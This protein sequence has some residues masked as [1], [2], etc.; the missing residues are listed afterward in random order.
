MTQ[1]LQNTGVIRL[2]SVQSVN[3]EI[4]GD[5]R[6]LIGQVVRLRLS[7]DQDEPG[8][9]ASVLAKFS[10]PDP[11]FRLG[12]AQMYRR[13]I[14]FYDTVASQLESSVPRCYFGAMDES[15]G[16]S[17][18][19]IEDVVHA[20]TGDLVEGCTIPEAELA[21]KQLAHIHAA[22]WG[23]PKLIDWHWMPNF[24]EAGRAD[25]DGLP[26]SEKYALFRERMAEIFPEW[27]LPAIFHAT[28][29]ALGEHIVLA[30]QRLSELPVTLL[31]NDP[32]LDNLLF[33]NEDASR[34]VSLIDWQLAITG[35]G[36]IDLAYFM[37]FSLSPEQCR[38]NEQRLIAIYH[39]ALCAQGV[40]GFSFDQ[41]VSEYRLALLMPFERLV[42][43]VCFLSISDG[44]GRQIIEAV[45]ER[46]IPLVV[47]RRLDVLL[48]ELF[49]QNLKTEI[50]A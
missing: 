47:D 4:I 18:L 8:A 2:A 49:S 38:L 31:H 11:A 7:Y 29:E 32:H 17:I 37:A 13:E 12:A 1:V 40:V 21:I 6:G 46:F 34:P 19:L 44:R 50:V 10:S 43:V 5:G 16:E 30:K 33:G 14:A 15:T 22:Y 45:L 28:G 27:P 36:A 3:C 41:L 20:R 48:G 24:A 39:A 23:H 42:I 35:R 25:E 9:L 26:F